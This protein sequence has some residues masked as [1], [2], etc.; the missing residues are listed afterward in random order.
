MPPDLADG[1]AD[2]L[3]VQFGQLAG[4]GHLAVTERG[5]QINQRTGQAVRAFQ[6]DQGVWELSNPRK[7]DLSLG[8]LAR[9]IP[10]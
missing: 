7:Q 5:L 9:Q 1:A 3:F 6:K 10:R 8:G 4:S 2:D